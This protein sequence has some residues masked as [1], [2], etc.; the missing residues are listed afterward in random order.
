[1]ELKVLHVDAQSGFYKLER[2]PVGQ[3]LGPVD[4][5]L[6]CAIARN[7]LTFGGGLFA[8]S[9]IPGS[10][11]L[12][13]SGFSPCWGGFYVSSMGGAALVFDNLGISMVS[14][15][16]RAQKPSILVLNREHGEEIDVALHAVDVG[17]VWNGFGGEVGI[18]ALIKHA[19][20]SHAGEYKEMPRVI[21]TGP[22]AMHTDLGA[23]GSVVMTSTG[24]FT[25]V[26]TWAGR[27]GLGSK[28]L[29]EHNV[30]A[31][32]Y[33]GTV[34]DEDFRDRKVVDGFFEKHYQKK[35]QIKDL[36]A[37]KK[38]RFDP[39][40]DTGGTF[41]VNY[42]KIGG[43]LM[44]FNYLSCEWT[45]DER[46]RVHKELI[47]DH[48]LKQFNEETIKTKSFH[49]CGEPCAAVCKKLNGP[50]KKD[51]EPYQT[52]GPLA[53]VFDQRGAEKLNHA[54]D[55]GGFDGISIGGV[56]SWL[57][58]CVDRDI[59]KP[60]DLGLPGKPVFKA[61]GF[62]VVED[63]AQ[64]AEIGL[65]LIEGMLTGNPMLDMRRGARELSHIIREKTGKNARDLFVCSS[66]G[67][68]GW[69][70]PNQYWCPGAISPMPIMGKYYMYYGYDFVPPRNLGRMH[71]DRM[72]KELIMDNFGV[73]RFHRG[74]AEDLLPELAA[75]LLGIKDGLQDRHK[76][77]ASRIAS[78]NSS[79]FWE[80]EREIDF[81]KSYLERCLSV[82]GVKR[83]ELDS[84]V[85]AFRKDK[86]AAAFDWWFE[87]FK[88]IHESLREY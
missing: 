3:F 80:A 81:M 53:G 6:H 31:V 87:V 38:Y 40:F 60:E 29:Q 46:K 10:N 62:R 5:G 36:E 48:Y 8:G 54:A 55:S 32:V 28:M 78:R 37:T 39:E 73:C 68:H 12:I 18:Y 42:A 69:M 84:W 51:Y 77:I 79:V 11:R 49:N 2:F 19:F 76:K 4:L 44:A 30:A 52:M 13:F 65:K 27:G 70:V 1:M 64:N 50:Y 67:R 14:I 33:G 24:Q 16:G 88:G 59:L 75:N 45:E 7:A 85:D 61:A 22:A 74:W 26:D 41:G 17:A 58:E 21:A 47:L 57:M 63:S 66:F 20:K 9:V 71:A 34:V 25:H 15:S 35:M 83:P 86:K 72:V 82:D 43:R 23:I 56:V